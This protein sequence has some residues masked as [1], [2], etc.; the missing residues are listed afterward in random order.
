[1]RFP[2]THDVAGA[3]VDQSALWKT[4]DSAILSAY[5][6]EGGLEVVQSDT[7][8]H[9]LAV[10]SRPWSARQEVSTSAR[11]VMAYLLERCA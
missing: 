5:D 7:K 9:V 4:S 1:M 2:G 10:L 8:V 6:L 11:D 3:Y